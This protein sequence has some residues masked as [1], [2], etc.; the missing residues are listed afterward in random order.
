M[1]EQDEVYI[2][3]PPTSERLSQKSSSQS[4]MDRHA[5]PPLSGFK[6]REKLPLP[7]LKQRENKSCLPNMYL[8]G[9]PGKMA[10]PSEL[11]S[12][13][14]LGFY[15]RSDNTYPPSEELYLEVEHVATSSSPPLVPQ[16]QKGT[17][18]SIVGF[19]LL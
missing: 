10:N 1:D 3:D 13:T 17:S 6:R 11:K 4:V 9:K 12:P 7:N 19:N 2:N 18:R 14:P 16:K 5:T 8:R 15:Q